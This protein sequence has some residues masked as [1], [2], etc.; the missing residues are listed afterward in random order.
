MR[1]M[2]FPRPARLYCGIF[3]VCC[4][5][6]ALAAPFCVENQ[7]LPPQCNYYDATECQKDAVRQGGVCDANPQQIALQP[8]IG[9]Y[10]VVSSEGASSCVYSDRG[11]CMAA[12]ARLGGAYTAAP[13]VAPS[14]APDPYAAINGQ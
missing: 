14:R 10:C 5:S 12:A 9:Q 4:S 3:L 7:A 11:T 13:T 2:L 1:L 8:G 6:T